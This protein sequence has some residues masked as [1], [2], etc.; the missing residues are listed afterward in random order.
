MCGPEQLNLWGP[1]TPWEKKD[2]K[3]KTYRTKEE[4][5]RIKP[6]E[7]LVW[8]ERVEDRDSDD[9]DEEDIGSNGDD[10]RLPNDAFDEWFVYNK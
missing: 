9:D 5:Q 7:L 4:L 6:S 1:T 2:S 3:T 10:D 8:E